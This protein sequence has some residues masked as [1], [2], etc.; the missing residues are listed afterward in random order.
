MAALV[1]VDQ[2][3]Q[4]LRLS[5][6][7]DSIRQLTDEKIQSLRANL[8]ALSGELTPKQTEVFSRQI[9]LLEIQKRVKPE[10]ITPSSSIPSSS[11][12]SS[13]S[14]ASLQLSF[15]LASSSSPSSIPTPVAS[16]PS[17]R[18]EPAAASVPAPSNNMIVLDLINLTALIV[19][20]RVGT[21]S[22]ADDIRAMRALFRSS[23]LGHEK[24]AI[25]RR[26]LYGAVA[27][28]FNQ[29]DFVDPLKPNVRYGKRQIASLEAA[30]ALFMKAHE[31]IAC[32]YRGETIL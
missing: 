10:P 23:S 17:L 11:L 28:H 22:S 15:S 16:S 31:L 26:R 1:S 9:K 29:M 25:I 20:R 2:F 4:N 5:F 18:V 32:L 7:A 21:E 19:K 8:V 3:R 6:N 24:C 30:D 13:S 14:G 12:A 27:R